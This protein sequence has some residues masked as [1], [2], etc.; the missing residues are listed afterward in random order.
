LIRFGWSELT[1]LKKLSLT[2]NDSDGTEYHVELLDKPTKPYLQGALMQKERW[3]KHTRTDAPIFD[4]EWSDTK[5]LKDVRV[6]ESHY[7][8]YRLAS[9]FAAIGLSRW[10]DY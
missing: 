4:K 10:R 1:N 3:Y 6:N 7:E 8:Y 2:C 9:P 5:T